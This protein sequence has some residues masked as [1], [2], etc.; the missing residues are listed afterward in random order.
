[1]KAIISNRIYINIEDGP[2]REAIKKT[3]TYKIPL[4]KGAVRPGGLPYRTLKTFQSYTGSLISIPVGR[5]DLIPKSAEIVDKR[6]CKEADFPEFSFELRQSQQDIYDLVEDNCIINAPPSWGKTFTACAIAKKLGL[7]TLI[8]VHNTVLRD[9][10]ADE[11]RKVFGIEP[12]IIGSSKFKVDSPIVV[13]NTQTLHKKLPQIQNLF[14]TVILDEMHHVSSRT[15]S[16]IVDSLQCRYKI[17][18]S[19]TL[20]RKDGEHVVFPDYFG[21][22]VYVAEKE[23]SLTPEVIVL[24]TNMQYSDDAPTFADKVT[25]L[26]ADPYYLKLLET[27]LITLKKKGYVTLLPLARTEAIDSLV[28]KLPNFGKMHSGVSFDER[29]VFNT[30]VLEGRSDGIIATQ[31]IVSEG[32]SNNKLSALILGTPVNNDAL[33]EQLI[34]R[35]CRMYDGKGT[36]LVIDLKINCPMGKNQYR[37][38]YGYYIRSGYK[39]TEITLDQL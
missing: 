3:L 18:L 37:N 12:G 17:G 34:G 20:K 38:R 5:L 7:K 4:P 39:V 33:L 31:S 27:L 28:E 19:A 15:V 25:S 2:T 29:K 13:G 24:N 23:N 14:G 36:P 8:V 22:K 21:S 35:I 9:Q 10:W 1:M 16:S 11:I 26:M 6:I 30:A 32:Y